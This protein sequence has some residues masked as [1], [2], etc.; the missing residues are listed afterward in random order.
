MTPDRQPAK[1]MSRP[2]VATGIAGTV[3]IAALAFWLSFTALRQLAIRAGIAE[4]QAWAWPLIVDGVI[5]VATVGVVAMRRQPGARYAWALLGSG[6]AVS[7]S[8]NAI[9]AALPPEVFLNPALA[10]AVSSVPPIVLLAITHLT[11]VLTRTEPTETE[12]PSETPSNAV[13]EPPKQQRTIATSPRDVAIR[14][15]TGPSNANQPTEPGGSTGTV[16][17]VT[18]FDPANRRRGDHPSPADEVKQPA[19]AAVIAEESEAAKVV[20]APSA[21]AKPNPTTPKPPVVDGVTAIADRGG[22]EVDRTWQLETALA[23]KAEGV[24]NREIATRVGVGR[25]TIARW[26][27]ETEETNAN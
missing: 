13:A 14:S 27:K 22:G 9:E 20:R 17:A 16:Q 25:T 26:L 1:P 4:R 6:A 23:L 12:P 8:A 3:F 11:V 24:S 7:V 19:P 21:R 2:V 15:V 10:A 18:A 5:V